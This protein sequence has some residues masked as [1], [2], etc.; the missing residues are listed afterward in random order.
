M[1]ATPNT[2]DITV[3]PGYDQRQSLLTGGDLVELSVP[4]FDENN[5]TRR[6]LTIKTRHQTVRHV[7]GHLPNTADVTKDGYWSVSQL[8]L[9]IL[10]MALQMTWHVNARKLMWE[11]GAT[12]NGVQ[13]SEWVIPRS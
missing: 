12:V 5:A 9:T 11:K 8:H 13:N 2:P 3:Q 6:D 10:S 4:L 7:A 1:T